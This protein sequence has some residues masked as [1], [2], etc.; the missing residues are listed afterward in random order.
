MLYNVTGDKS[1]FGKELAF[2][3]ASHRFLCEP[4]HEVHSAIS[5]T[6]DG[7]NATPNRVLNR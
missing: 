2:S 1:G 4:K 5:R 3:L 6:C 7:L